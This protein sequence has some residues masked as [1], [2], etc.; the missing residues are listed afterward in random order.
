ALPSE[1]PGGA[2]ADPGKMRRIVGLVVGGVG[3]AGIT[4][5]SVFGVLAKQK[6]DQSNGGSCDAS[7]D[8][9]H[10]AG[11]PQRKDAEHAAT[12][13]D[14][15]FIAGGVLLAAGAVIFFTA[16]KGAPVTGVVV[17]P[18]PVAGGGGAILRAEF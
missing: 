12:V 5:G 11:F 18:A 13:S 1:P 9:C 17:A 7:T 15:G 8:Q 2:P 4:V 14:V 6:L 3:V 10:P 16:P